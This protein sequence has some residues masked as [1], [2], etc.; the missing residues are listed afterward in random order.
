MPHFA[1]A[2]PI[3]AEQGESPARAAFLIAKGSAEYM[4]GDLET[5]LAT[6]GEALEMAAR[7]D[8]AV[9]RGAA[10]SI[11]CV[12]YMGMGRNE[13]ATRV[14]NE[15]YE[16]AMRHNVGIIA[17]FTATSANSNLLLLPR[18]TRDRMLAELAKGYAS[19]APA[20][21]GI[22]RANLVTAPAPLR[23]SSNRKQL[24]ETRTRSEIR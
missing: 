13:D 24:E 1:A 10:L 15:A 21:Q 9:I 22:L 5:S 20:Q 16:I 6:L 17:A 18:L 11:Q 8:N 12:A 19:Q 7:I 14:S 3:F 4:A 23:T 2:E